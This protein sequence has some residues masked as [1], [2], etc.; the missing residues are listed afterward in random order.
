MR[1]VSSLFFKRDFP[2]RPREYLKIDKKPFTFNLSA[3]TS[4][5]PILC[6]GEILWDA[7]GDEKVAGGAPMNVARHLVQQG[8]KVSFA[9]RIGTGPSG[10]DLVKFLKDGG[11]FSKLVQLD[12][13]LPT[14]KVTVQLDRDGHA[15]YIIPEPVS[16]DNIQPDS[17]LD[18]A[19]QQA[20]A[21][22]FGTLAC[23]EETTRNTLL[24]LLAKT[25]A[26]KVF[27][28]NLRPPH[29]TME[30]IE[31][32]TRS[33][34]VIKMNDDEAALLMEGFSENHRDSMLKY[35]Q[36]YNLQTVCITR[37]AHGAIVLHEDQFFEH[38]GFKVEVVDT[39][40]AGD[41]FLAAFVN[42][43]LHH[44]PMP[45]VLERACK[46]GAF[47][48]GKRGANPVYDESVL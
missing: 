7:F 4:M 19:A 3:F 45:E 26:L 6:F 21:I 43:L 40:G 1:Q 17:A 42:G 24:G 33:A 29:Y 9:T 41:S 37:G 11:L 38:P 22:V 32:F 14:C 23:R 8:A 44:K 30:T 12:H 28:V 27:D 25:S 16:W 20:S 36:K 31:A 47:V 5:K 46:I 15:T 39:V 48:A 35:Q 13:Q 34:D 2:I 18:E 10:Q